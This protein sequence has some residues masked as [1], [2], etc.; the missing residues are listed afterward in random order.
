MSIRKPNNMGWRGFSLPVKCILHKPAVWM[1][2]PSEGTDF[3]S[4]NGKEIGSFYSPA[5]HNVLRIAV[6]LLQLCE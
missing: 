3:I 6:L 4:P 2:L 1:Y 5:D